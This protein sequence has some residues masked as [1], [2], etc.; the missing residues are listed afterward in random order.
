[1]AKLEEIKVGSIIVGI[2]NSEPVTVTEVK[3]YGKSGISL[4]Y[5]DSSGHIY[6]QMLFPD[7]EKSIKIIDNGKTIVTFSGEIYEGDKT[8]DYLNELTFDF[9]LTGDIS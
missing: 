4:K 3:K 9:V 7:A 5:K 2:M 6:Y 8:T 1:M